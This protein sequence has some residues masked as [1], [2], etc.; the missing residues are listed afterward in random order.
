M[1]HLTSFIE[2]PM[3]QQVGSHYVQNQIYTRAGDIP[4]RQVPVISLLWDV[5][6]KDPMTAT[7]HQYPEGEFIPSGFFDRV[8]PEMITLL[9][10]QRPDWKYEMRRE[11]QMI[12][13]CLYLGPWACL[14]NTDPLERENF[15]LLL[16]IRDQQHAGS[17]RF[18]GDKAAAKLGIQTVMVDVSQGPSLLSMVSRVVW[19]INDH[20][21]SNSSPDS[22][23]PPRKVL[24]YCETGN[25][26][27]ALVAAAYLMVMLGIKMQDALQVVNSRR[28]SMEADED[29]LHLLE[30]FESILKAKRDVK[31]N[32]E[33]GAETNTA[34]ES[35]KKRSLGD[36]D[37]DE[38]EDMGGYND[39]H[40]AANGTPGRTF[41][42][43]FQDR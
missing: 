19:L 35:C 5:Y 41:L 33:S 4:Q 15:T 34:S 43:P 29:S 8:T 24:L 11:A 25:R 27:S 12:L 14:K 13:P 7:D 17:K 20:L 22:S 39:M 23:M 30:A 2:T 16:G 28:L 10:A 36:R 21:A 9:P 1:S 18:L 32:R 6:P 38:D 3:S 37:G 26:T 40:E 31:K 42:A